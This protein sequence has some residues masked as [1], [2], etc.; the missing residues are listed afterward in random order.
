[1]QDI[2]ADLRDFILRYIDSVAQLEA[3]LL[4]REHP[5]QN[6]SSQHLAGRLYISSERAESLLRLLKDEGIVEVDGEKFRY[7]GGT[8]EQKRI[9]DRLAQFYSSHLVTV[10]NLI[11]SRPSRIREFANAFRLKKDE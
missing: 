6:W 3:L 4:L 10:T 1:M 5:S 7:F 11:H 8:P 9:I 2:P